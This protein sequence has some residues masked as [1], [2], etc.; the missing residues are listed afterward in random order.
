M[1]G[2][3]AVIERNIDQQESHINLEQLFNTS[4]LKTEEIKNIF[5]KQL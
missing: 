1:V 2:G 3:F 5:N 4:I